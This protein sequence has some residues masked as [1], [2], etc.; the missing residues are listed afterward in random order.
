MCSRDESYMTVM[1]ILMARVSDLCEEVGGHLR[2]GLAGVCEGGLTLTD[3]VELICPH[4]LVDAVVLVEWRMAPTQAISLRIRFG[5]DGGWEAEV[6]PDPLG[7]SPRAGAAYDPGDAVAVLSMAIGTRARFSLADIR[8]WVDRSDEV[9]GGH[10]T[11]KGKY[12]KEVDD[13][14]ISDAV[15]L[16]ESLLGRA[17]GGEALEN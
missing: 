14:K 16:I 3:W 7:T 10:C 8:R 9:L 4:G 12:G 13:V 2:D 15:A 11:N 1:V 5:L 6:L 17:G